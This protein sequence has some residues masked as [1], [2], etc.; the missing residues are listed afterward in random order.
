MSRTL[1]LLEFAEHLHGLVEEAEGGPE[2]ASPHHLKTS[3]TQSLVVIFNVKDI[4]RKSGVM[5]QVCNFVSEFQENC[6]NL[7]LIPFTSCLMS[8]S[9][10]T[11]PTF[12]VLSMKPSSFCADSTN[13]NFR[14]P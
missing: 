9:P 11:T 1:L 3:L 5:S 10:S 12:L 2:V 7:V 13:G 4:C 14:K 6:T 8:F